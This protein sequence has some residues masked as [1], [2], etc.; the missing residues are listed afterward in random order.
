[1]GAR[2]ETTEDRAGATRSRRGAEGATAGG[3]AGP[4]W[5]Y[6]YLIRLAEGFD[7]PATVD[8]FADQVYEWERERGVRKSW[9]DVHEELYR[10]DLPV[11]DGAGL[12]EFDVEQGLVWPRDEA[13]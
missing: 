2:N 3:D 5:R 11:L 4:T 10:I 13:S 6:R 9:T 12:V 1:M 8:E 7:P